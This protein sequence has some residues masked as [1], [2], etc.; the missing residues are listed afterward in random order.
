MIANRPTG[1][2]KDRFQSSL[3]QST[4]QP[5]SIERID[6]KKNSVNE[7]SK[8]NNK[9]SNAVI[10]HRDAKRS[11]ISLRSYSDPEHFTGMKM[12]NS[13][14][15]IANEEGTTF[16]RKGSM[17]VQKKQFRTTGSNRQM[18]SR[19]NKQL[20]QFLIKSILPI[21]QREFE[22]KL[23]QLNL[24]RSWSSPLI[25]NCIRSSITPP[26]R[27]QLSFQNFNE[28]IVFN[29][30]ITRN[31]AILC[32][33]PDKQLESSIRKTSVFCFN[34]NG[35]LSSS[36][37]NI[38]LCLEED[39][40]PL[41]EPCTYFKHN[42]LTKEES[43]SSAS[44]S[45]NHNLNN[46]HSNRTSKNFLNKTDLNVSN[47]NQQYSNKNDGY[48][49]SQ[50]IQINETVNESDKCDDNEIHSEEIPL[51]SKQTNCSTVLNN[52]NTNYFQQKRALQSVDDQDDDEDD[53]VEEET[54]QNANCNY[55][56]S[57]SKKYQNKIASQPE[58]N[59]LLLKSFSGSTGRMNRLGST[60]STTTAYNTAISSI[61]RSPYNQVT[62]SSTTSNIC[63]FSSNNY[64]QNFN[65]KLTSSSGFNSSLTGLSSLTNNNAL[66]KLSIDTP[67]AFR[68]KK[69][70]MN[71]FNSASL[72]PSIYNTSNYTFNNHLNNLNNSNFNG[73]YTNLANSNTGTSASKYLPTTDFFLR[74]SSPSS[75]SSNFSSVNLS[76]GNYLSNYLTNNNQT[77]SP[78][79]SNNYLAFKSA[80]TTGLGGTSTNYR[81]LPN[82]Y[83]STSG[84]GY[85]SS[86]NLYSNRYGV[87]NQPTDTDLSLMR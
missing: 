34:N 72:S 73:S 46:H 67:M 59:S 56:N 64:H 51:K 45:S 6:T 60:G 36:L 86:S 53:D 11:P 50:T 35:L 29:L 71:L 28:D 7:G 12:T 76:S 79:S 2:I 74:Q 54:D 41:N 5:S 78:L 66:T 4:K 77:S 63:N 9:I 10:R 23:K 58:N 70:S 27:Q 85:N 84:V 43:G 82:S 57:S 80:N 62:R 40:I 13:D 68:R 49:K 83:S 55:F 52:K 33:K 19:S 25:T 8:D 3:Q 20:N 18:I 44:N 87:S 61:N 22:K 15:L 26:L 39:R 1:L 47:K 32:S 37:P 14:F 81:P 38:H 75:S 31:I 17:N 48:V 16:E 24:P 65:S 21:K 30:D 42:N 69:R